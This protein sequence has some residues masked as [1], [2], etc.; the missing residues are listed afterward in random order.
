[1]MAEAAR[2][3]AKRGHEVEILTTTARSHVSWSNDFEP[4]SFESDGVVVRRFRTAISRGRLQAAELEHRVQRGEKLSETDEIA[5]VN[6]R[7]S[8]PDL[9]LYL[10]AEAKRYDALV[11]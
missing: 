11:F 5:W 6:G 1:M 7:F 8:V 10:S 3:L 4:G 2:G 9:Y